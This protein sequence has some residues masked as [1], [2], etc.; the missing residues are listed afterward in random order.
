MG[1]TADLFVWR[2]YLPAVRLTASV[3][4]AA[5]RTCVRMTASTVNAGLKLTPFHRSKIDPPPLATDR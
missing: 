4:G 5:S 2:A 1:W 3:S